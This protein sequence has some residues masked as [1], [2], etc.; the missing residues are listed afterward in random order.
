M[1]WMYLYKLLFILAD[2]IFI[3]HRNDSQIKFIIIFCRFEMINFICELF[4]W[5]KK[6]MQRM[7]YYPSRNFIKSK[8]LVYRKL[9]H[10]TVFDSFTSKNILTIVDLSECSQDGMIW[11]FIWR[12]QRVLF[13]PEKRSYKFRLLFVGEAENIS[14][15]KYIQT[16]NSII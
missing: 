8:K 15:H 12:V 1:Q 4:H 11:I 9:V 13:A 10:C 7:F 2:L 6:K 5:Q 3:C 14:A 16:D